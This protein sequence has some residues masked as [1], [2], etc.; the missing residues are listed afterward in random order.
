MTPKNPTSVMAT[1]RP[2][3]TRR[4]RSAVVSGMSRAASRPAIIS[5]MTSTDTQVRR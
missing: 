4:R 3:G 5:G 2:F 1:A